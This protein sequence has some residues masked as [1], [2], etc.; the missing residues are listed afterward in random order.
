[1]PRPLLLAA[2]SL[3][4][5][6]AWAFQLPRDAGGPS[7][8]APPRA[9]NVVLV[10]ADDLGWG[11]LGS[12]GQERIRTPN[13]DRLAAEGMRWTRFY[14]GSPVCA[15]SRCVLMTG[16]H[17]GHA[18]VRDNREMGGWKE[19]DPEGQLPLPEGTPTLARDLRNAGIAT[20]CV[21][22]WGL[23]GPGSSGMPDRQGFDHFFGY[24][25]Q[26]Q[27]HDY[28]PTHLWRDG[29]RVDLPGNE[30]GNLVGEHY[31]H[32]LMT[33]DALRWVREH[34]DERFFL[35]LAY[36]VP[37]LALQVP[38]DSLA[39]YVG[40]WDDPPYDGKKGYL[41]HPHPRA[42]YAAMV[43]RMDRDVGRLLALLDELGVA[44]DT[45]VIF[46]S[47]NGGTYDI[48]GAHTDFFRSNGPF[49]G[50][51]GSVYE[52]GIRVPFL[53]RM[54]GT[55]PAGVVVEAPGAFWDLRPTVDDALGVAVPDGLDGRS[56]WP[57]LTGR[58]A[59]DPER[60]LYWE[61]PGYGGQRALS[62]GSWKLVQRNLRKGPATL[63]LFHLGRDPGETTDLSERHPEL[64][65]ALLALMDREHEP[66][67]EFPMPGVD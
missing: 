23:G 18:Y 38:D 32:D 33:D 14:S 63:E 42:A 57:A 47:D 17:T 31:S 34:G 24:L 9:R 62:L 50:Y 12:Y 41:P 27:A 26:R 1:M 16:L 19:G 2:A 7:E 55:V 53:A 6:P 30:W 39:E 21:G 8:A 66:S 5:A 52:G 36:T 28:Y 45:L 56:L 59:A 37:H 44:E 10:V 61:F 49:R 54:P 40:L 64:V 3:L 48:G 43:T 13:L 46:T 20:G 65:R 29:E 67:S 11:D 51:K 15:P 58:E 35:F 25:C 60:L 22:K 4:A